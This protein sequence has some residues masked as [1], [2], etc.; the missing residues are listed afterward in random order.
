VGQTQSVEPCHFSLL[1][2]FNVVF[3]EK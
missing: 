2:L 1:T 3:C